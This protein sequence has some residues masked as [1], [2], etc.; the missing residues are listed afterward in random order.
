MTDTISGKKLFDLYSNFLEESGKAYDFT[1]S[2]PPGGE[3]NVLA[4]R[5]DCHVVALYVK[6][7]TYHCVE[8]V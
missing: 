1:C 8:A 7:V 5:L 4:S 3:C 6:F 2:Q